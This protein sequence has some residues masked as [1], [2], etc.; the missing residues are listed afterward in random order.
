[1]KKVFALVSFFIA[2]FGI[3]QTT[4]AHEREGVRFK[5]VTP[6]DVLLGTGHYLGGVGKGVWKGTRTIIHAPFKATM[7]LP[8]VREY[9]YVPG[10]WQEIR[11]K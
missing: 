9:R 10:Y 6:C 4:K 7:P 3:G 8:P 5:C 1:M 2:S 11:E